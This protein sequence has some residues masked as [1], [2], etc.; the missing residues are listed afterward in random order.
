[1]LNLLTNAIK[2]GPGKPVAVRLS[3]PQPGTVQLE[4]QDQGIGLDPR[5]AAR[6]FDRF[7]R[8]VSASH[9]GGLG[10]GLYI[11]RQIVQAHHGDIQVRSAPDRGATFT[12]T[13][14][15]EANVGAMDPML[16]LGAHA[17]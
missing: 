14:P 3:T 17:S 12:V 2:Y 10:L 6:I 16:I 8:A 15:V 5:D 7:E 1:V 9:Y 11:A 13:L 4:V